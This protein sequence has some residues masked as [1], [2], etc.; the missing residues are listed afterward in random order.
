MQENVCREVPVPA[1]G[2]NASVRDYW[3]LLRPGILGMVL[4]TLGVAA[5]VARPELPPWHVLA[6]AIVGSG[7]LIA[8]ALA[9]NQRIEHRSDA[10]MRRTR[11]RPLPS[12]RISARQAA[13]FGAA[14]SIAGLAYLA[15]FCNA[16]VVVIGLASWIIYV[17]LYT[18]LKMFSAWQT[19]LGAL[20]GAMPILMGTAAAG[21]TFSSA[22]LTLFGILYFWQ[23]PHAMAI[24]WLY[25]EDFGAA[26]LKVAS[27][28]DP[29]GRTAAILS[30]AGAVLLV[31]ASLASTFAGRT[32]WVYGAAAIAAG[33]FYLACAA[34]FYA[35]RDDLTARR[36]LRASLLY[37]PVV[38]VALLA[39]AL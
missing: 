38:C 29:S 21:D 13:W 6:H 11:R 39:A 5:L 4:F 8:G 37:L 26:G 31:P 16:S 33:L 30:L 23:F 28:T 20:S 17:W 27:V 1:F 24:A 35:R 34:V 22:G 10:M 15:V 32:G 14:T 9:L 18:P 25:R 7:L 12:G 3:Q 36:L 19:P 2:G